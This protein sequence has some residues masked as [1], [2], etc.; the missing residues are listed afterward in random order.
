MLVSGYI[1]DRATALT[2]RAL[3]LISFDLNQRLIP[4]R[5]SVPV[6]QNNVEWEERV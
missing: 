6:A 2:Q 3:P 4:E 1:P 5:L